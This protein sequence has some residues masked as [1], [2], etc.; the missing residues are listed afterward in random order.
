M[1]EPPEAGGLS[2]RQP[3]ADVSL[4]YG[5]DPDTKGAPGLS[6]TS[7][8]DRANFA[9]EGLQFRP[10]LNYYGSV[11]VS[12]NASDGGAS[13]EGGVLSASST[14]SIAV[15]PV[16]DP[17]EVVVPRVHRR[18]GGRGPVPIEGLYIDDVDNVDSESVT[19]VI[20][21]DE[22]SISLDPLPAVS[23]S[24]AGSDSAGSNGVT[25][26]GLLADVRRALLHVWFVLPSE[27]WVGGT[28][29]SFSATDGQGTTGT[30]ECVVVVTDPS[31]E[32]TI[33]AEN[34]TFVVDQGLA[35]PLSALQV[36]DLV[37]DAAGLA[38][39]PSPA[40]NVT[41]SAGKGG[42][43][44]SPIP[45]GLSPVPGTETA[46]HA[47]AAIHSGQGLAGMFGIPRPTLSFRGALAAVNE[48]FGALKY[49][50]ANGTAGLGNH[51]VVV[52]VG[53]RGNT[54]DYSTRLHLVVDVLPVNQP[55]V[56]NWNRTA[57]NTLESP[58]IGWFSL[59]GLEVVDSDLAHGGLLSVQIQALVEGESV[60]VSSAG[61]GIMFSQG[62]ADS[63]P[64]SIVKFVGNA[65]NIARAMSASAV[66]LDD[67]GVHRVCPLKVTAT[68]EDGGETS[69]V[70]EIYATHVNS[71]PK[72]TISN[73]QMSLMEGSALERVGERAGVEVTDEDV[74]NSSDGFL[75]VNV[76]TSHRAVLEVQT[77][78]TSATSIH[79][80]QTVTTSSA[81]NGSV[82]LEGTFNLTLDLSSFCDT[83]RVEETEPLWH[84]AVANEDDVRVGLGSGSETGESLQAKLEALPSLQALG[85][86][87]FCQRDNGLSSQGGR[88]WRVTFIDAPASLP[89]MLA[90]GDSLI[91][92]APDIKVAYAVK[93]NSLSGSLTVSF[94]GYET[95][96]IRHDAEASKVA[97]ALEALPSVTAV[98]VS[99]P[100]AADAQGGLHW[101]V[102]FFDATG[103]GGD[104]PLMKADGQALDA[105]GA[106]V[107]VVEE[108]QGEGTAELWQVSTSATHHNLVSVITMTGALKAKGFFQIGLDYGG[109]HTWTRAIY[110]KA[111]ALAS[112][113]NASWWSFGGTPGRKSG[114][115]IEARLLSLENWYELGPDAGVLV[116]RVESSDG[117]TIEWGLTFTGAPEDL[118]EPIVRGTHLSGGAVVS[119]AVNMSHNRVDG[120]FSLAYGGVATLPLAHD[121]SGAVLT[122]AL[123]ALQSLHTS[124]TRT[125]VVVG[126]RTQAATLEGGRRWV[127]AFLSDPEFPADFTASGTSA[128]GL[129]GTS[130]RVSVTLMRRGGRGAILRLVDLGGAAFGLPGYT[131]GERL[132]IRGRPEMITSAL[133]SM[134][135]SPLPG[136][137]GAADI[138]FRAY[139][140]GFTGAGGAQSGWAML[141]ATVAAVNNPPELL[142]CGNVVGWGGARIEG[143]DEDAP[144]RLVD[145][146]CEG[147]G[148]PV[149]PTA[150]DHV[151]LGGPDL[152]LQLRDPDGGASL[153]QVRREKGCTGCLVLYEADAAG[154][155]IGRYELCSCP[156]SKM[157]DASNGGFVAFDGC[158]VSMNLCISP[159]R[160]LL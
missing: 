70:V 129:A 51:S 115:S 75:E 42:I 92:D 138:I 114:E 99:R 147:G 143:V 139:D 52:E 158:D 155:L 73:S 63:V 74:E 78:T 30:A 133:A 91:G 98:D 71:P 59:S 13:G 41:V 84:N 118:A 90:T 160:Y 36:R 120:F 77:I 17:P 134:S 48:A 141:R 131:I 104:L 18:S 34:V 2:F 122:A 21:A 96:P 65:T 23:T 29:V 66:V 86:T 22:G 88:E 15:L 123:N 159:P 55:P 60:V 156:P 140:G 7:G 58:Q 67:P 144:F 81:G 40:F 116:S 124:D 8:L 61:E 151:D 76:S 95:E 130:A 119:V 93:G 16:N 102:T 128:T 146:D 132:T 4:P 111:V 27:G 136:W 154:L 135:Y 137:N 68:D 145:Y 103:A 105:R 3:G 142:W 80:V 6:L 28:V 125:G 126:T 152:G 97:A 14:I 72:V 108:V 107:R 39:L 38:G 87:V 1:V 50:S 37:A 148:T 157:C 89:M 121:S 101:E 62:S 11:V 83:C 106:A 57:A 112:D 100:Y 45:P 94:G 53:R 127:V 49:V 10:S 32:P 44:L 26:A 110:P 79:P 43:G 117:N 113:E 149:T 85:V 24:G 9:L 46:T 64:S 20:T 150:F 54:Q 25:I 19:V 153:V 5:L 33:I 35:S 69:L 31:I 47:V 109:R 12:I 56:I 82:T